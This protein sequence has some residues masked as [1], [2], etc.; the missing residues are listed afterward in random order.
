MLLLGRSL[1][2]TCL[3]LPMLFGATDSAESVGS[4]ARQLLEDGGYQLELPGGSGGSGSSGSRSRGAWDDGE[5]SASRRDARPPI[6]ASGFAPAKPLLWGLIV[7]LSVLLLVSLVQSLR[8][9]GQ[10]RLGGTR[11]KGNDLRDERGGRPG[12]EPRRGLGGNEA[13]SLTETSADLARAGRFAEAVHM[14]LLESLL[15]LQRHDGLLLEPAMTSRELVAHSPLEGQ[16]AVAFGALVSAVELS[17]FGGCAMGAQDY[18]AAAV[19][20]DVVT[21]A[22]PASAIEPSGAV[23]PS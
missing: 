9:P 12:H 14:A 11:A 23:D 3:V 10:Q 16:R 5:R 8:A 15:H 4:A 17:F 2:A 19:Q 1:V 20:L 22:E 13:S 21:S 7:V 6:K 18:A